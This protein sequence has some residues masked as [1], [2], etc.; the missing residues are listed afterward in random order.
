ML[1]W[2]QHHLAIKQPYQFS[3]CCKTKQ[4]LFHVIPFMVMGVSLHLVL[5]HS[6]AEYCPDITL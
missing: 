1:P 5:V 2:L 4:K 6:V 3:N